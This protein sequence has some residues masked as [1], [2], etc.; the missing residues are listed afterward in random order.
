MKKKTLFVPL[1]ALTLVG[2]HSKYAYSSLNEE[3]LSSYVENIKSIQQSEE[4]GIKIGDSFTYT[5]EDV[6]NSVVYDAGYVFNKEASRI[7]DKTTTISYNGEERV[8]QLMTEDYYDNKQ[9]LVSM[10]TSFILEKD[11]GHYIAT[12]NMLEMTYFIEKKLGD[13]YEQEFFEAAES[14][15]YR[16]TDIKREQYLDPNNVQKEFDEVARQSTN[17]EWDVVEETRSI[18]GKYDSNLEIYYLDECKTNTE[19]GSYRTVQVVYDWVQGI[20]SSHFQMFDEQLLKDDDSGTEI[21]KKIEETFR[22]DSVVTAPN[23]E[24]LTFVE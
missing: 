16:A 6:N 9:H 2:C 13:N 8:F 11:D 24:E 5:K 20:F 19:N 1:L 15:L 10:L 21:Y 18:G 22:M 12:A 23:I 7:D 3:T 4:F 17:I 14:Y